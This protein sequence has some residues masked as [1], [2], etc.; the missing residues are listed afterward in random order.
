MNIHR[1]DL[2]PP[3]FLCISARALLITLTSIFLIL[4]LA[5]ILYDMMHSDFELSSCIFLIPQIIILIAALLVALW[6][7]H[8]ARITLILWL[9]FLVITGMFY[10]VYHTAG[11]ATNKTECSLNFLWQMGNETAMQNST[12]FEKDG[13]QPEELFKAALIFGYA[14]ELAYALIFGVT[15]LQYILV[16]RLLNYVS[17]IRVGDSNQI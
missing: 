10:V 8:I 6:A 2:L 12:M 16:K 4:C 11:M 15:Y 3:K 13:E 7:L 9:I 17:V 1:K 14:L 5:G